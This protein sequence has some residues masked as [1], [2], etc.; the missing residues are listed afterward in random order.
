M[1]TIEKLAYEYLNSDIYNT[2]GYNRTNIIPG[3]VE[4]TES[5]VQKKKRRRTRQALNKMYEYARSKYVESKR[6]VDAVMIE[7]E[8]LK[9]KYDEYK[10]KQD[11]YH[12]RML[13]LRNQIQQ[14]DDSGNDYIDV[15]DA[16]AYPE[17]IDFD[18]PENS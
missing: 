14:I 5:P 1:A 15:F 8:K 9:K 4:R 16:P 6:K 18:I 12:K 3:D 17:E 13:E 10:E 2:Y 11:K 7:G